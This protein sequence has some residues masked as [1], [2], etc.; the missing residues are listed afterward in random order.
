MEQISEY[1]KD[2]FAK[3]KLI[4]YLEDHEPEVIQTILVK[5]SV[6]PKEF[7]LEEISSFIDG[8]PDR[9]EEV[10]EYLKDY[11][12]AFTLKLLRKLYS[13]FKRSIKSERDVYEDEI[14]DLKEEV[15]ELKWEIDDLESDV[16][17]WKISNVETD[18]IINCIKKAVELL[19][20]YEIV[21]AIKDGLLYKTKNE[22]K[23][24]M[25]LLQG[26]IL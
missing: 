11:E 2:P 16:E 26:K 17:Y 25:A 18:N 14:N 13:H 15:R 8:K 22:V 12:K 6:E 1:L 24:F 5:H 9:E 7:T 3:D 20:N 21:D 23:E 19:Y 10:I 4:E